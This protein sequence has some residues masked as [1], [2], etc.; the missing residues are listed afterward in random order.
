M[1]V[2]ESRPHH[3][4]K[5]RDGR[6]PSRRP[7]SGAL[8]GRLRA[9]PLSRVYR[10][11]AVGFVFF[12]LGLNTGLLEWWLSSCRFRHPFPPLFL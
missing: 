5:R 10:G 9:C 12:L 1:T 4:E 6:S 2:A 11:F 3:L 8:T 7:G